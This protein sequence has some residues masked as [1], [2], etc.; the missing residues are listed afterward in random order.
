MNKKLIVTGLL[1]LLVGCKGDDG[2]KAEQDT[3][4][5]EKA[6]GAKTKAWDPALGTATVKGVVKFTGKPPRQRAVDT[7][8]E[9][10]CAEHGK[11]VDE[12][13][14]VNPDGTLK[15]VFVWVKQG[16][17]DWKFPTPTEPAVLD[18]RG[19]TFH[20]RVQGVLAG[21]PL[22]IRNDDPFLHNVHVFA[23]KNRGFNMG[24]PKKGMEAVKKFTRPEVMMSVKCDV[25]GWMRSFIGVVAHPYF[26]VTG[27]TGAFELK[28]LPP[29]EYTVEA[30]HEEYGT[31]TA[32]VTVADGE[33]KDIE[34]Q[35]EG[36]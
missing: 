31:K 17:E 8:A 5:A 36:Q 3:G 26:A 28:N 29:G 6:T 32:T 20:P 34:F 33:S 4:A 13:V 15:N 10:K 27:T 11:V 21:Q 16:L 25:H 1:V 22:S 14:V 7:S 2:K 9:P 24:Q 12:S 30:W 19:C 18:Q 35:F 23:K